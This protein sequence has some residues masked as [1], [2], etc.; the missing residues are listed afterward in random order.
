MALLLIVEG[1][2]MNEII[3]DL[4][5]SLRDKEDIKSPHKLL[6]ACLAR[7]IL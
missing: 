2:L 1:L 5:V 3:G 7:V 4:D 6:L